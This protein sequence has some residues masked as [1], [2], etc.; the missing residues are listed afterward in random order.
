[1]LFTERG[2]GRPF[3]LLHGGAGPASV[4][5]FA[6]LLAAS[7]PARAITPTHPGFD[8]TPLDKPTVRELAALYADLLDELDLDDV[9]VVGN[10]IGGW[11]T[12]ELALLHP[13][14]VSAVVI[15]DAVGIEVP[16]HPVADFFN[17]TFPQVAELSYANPARFAIN[18]A[19]IRPE[20]MAGNRKTLEVYAG[21]PSMID[22]SLRPRLAEI[23]HPTLIVWG[24]ADRIAD[25]HYGRAFA[26]SIPGAEFLVLP[27]TG[28]LPQIESPELLLPA[29]W[30]FARS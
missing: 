2:N 6:D 23:T 28:H 27:G 3:L 10:S 5:A 18:P 29:V 26:E 7:H 24:E 19:T 17:L 13:R 14:R 16:G 20:I 4:T 15:V 22:P 11:I 9:T 12:A 25:V 21:E 8:G 1:M 30:D